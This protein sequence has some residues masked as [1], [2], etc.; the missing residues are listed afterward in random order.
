MTPFRERAG[1]MGLDV[2]AAYKGLYAYSD[3]YCEVI[4]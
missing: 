4:Y 1:E 2:S 3:Q